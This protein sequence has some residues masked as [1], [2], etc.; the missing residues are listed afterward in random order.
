MKSNVPSVFG[1]LS[2]AP[3]AK[4]SGNRTGAR[5]CSEP[6]EIQVGIFSST[7][8]TSSSHSSASANTDLSDVVR[9]IGAP[10]PSSAYS[11]MAKG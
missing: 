4:V 11:L 3:S 10:A 2:Q 7:P 6:R 5:A 9:R 8:F 1:T